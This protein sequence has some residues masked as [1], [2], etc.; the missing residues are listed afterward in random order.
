MN[1]FEG[2]LQGRFQR[3]DVLEILP[4]GIL[5]FERLL[6]YLLSPLRLIL[7]TE[8]PTRH[9]LGLKNE[10]TKLGDNHMV[11]LRGAIESG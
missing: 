4:Q 7:T 9:I 11:D 8:N 10:N 6:V 2:Y 1:G 5:K 3:L